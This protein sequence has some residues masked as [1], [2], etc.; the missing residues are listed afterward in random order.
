MVTVVKVLER[1]NLSSG[2]AASVASMDRRY[3]VDMATVTNDNPSDYYSVFV[4]TAVAKAVV[5]LTIIMAAL[6]GN[7]LV[8]LGVWRSEK[9]RSTVANVFIVS[10]A[11]ADFM[12]ALLVMPFSAIQV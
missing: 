3:I 1:C 6:L 8:I 5:M 12:V 4:V 7:S 10:L 9:L 2:T 11:A